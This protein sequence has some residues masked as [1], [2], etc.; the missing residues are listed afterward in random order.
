MATAPKSATYRVKVGSVVVGSGKKEQS[1][2]VGGT[3]ELIAEDAERFL[4]AGIVE[5]V[6]VAAETA[7]AAAPAAAAAAPTDPAANTPPA[8]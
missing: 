2:E 4:A 7:P 6:T 8:K 3:V 1:V 5:P